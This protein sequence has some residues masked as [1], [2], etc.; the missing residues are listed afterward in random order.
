MHTHEYLYLE[1]EKSPN[2]KKNP[3]PSTGNSTAAPLRRFQTHAHR[4]LGSS[5]ASHSLSS[6]IAFKPRQILLLQQ[7]RNRSASAPMAQLKPD[8]ESIL[9]FSV[10]LWLQNKGF[11][12][13]FKRFC[14]AAQIEGEDWKAKAL[15][16]NEIFSKYQEISNSSCKDLKFQEKQEQVAD[17]AEKIAN[18]TT[19]EEIKGKKKKKKSKDDT[20]VNESEK[21]LEDTA[22]TEKINESYENGNEDE[23]GNASKKSNGDKMHELAED[24]SEKPKEKKKKKKSKLASQPLDADVPEVTEQKQ[25]V[26]SSE[27]A[28]DAEDGIHE[29]KK[30]SKKRKRMAPE[31]NQ[32]KS[33]EE[34]AIEESKSKKSKGLKEGKDVP[35]HTAF[36]EANGHA[37]SDALQGD[38]QE[39]SAKSDYES[40]KN[41][42]NNNELDKS[43]Q[44]KSASKQPKSSEPTTVKAFQRVK[45]DE[46][47]FVDDRLQDNS[48]WAKDGAE[49]GY[50]AKA[51]EVLGQVKGRGF[52]HEKTKKKRGS[53]RGGQID[54]HSHS[55]KFNYSDE[56]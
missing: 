14:T 39:F 32:N 20:S 23:S 49:T 27:K 6:L 2:L 28:E 8:D 3:S 30:A 1:R 26:L 41:A 16:L 19:A 22:V 34:V 13:V 24:Q 29:S 7:Q 11:S 10:A 53:Y 21:T 43:S 46:V 12:K 4:M 44:K 25:E 52:R 17:V 38:L 35:P 56:E 42:T 54:L 47:E 15:N 48:Y 40:A 45:I 18:G 55:I 36:P 5:N 31:E 33:G 9:I 37:K 51:Q 50:G